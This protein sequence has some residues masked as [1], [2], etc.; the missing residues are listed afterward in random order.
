M[1]PIDVQITI[2]TP[3]ARASA[4]GIQPTGMNARTSIA[5]SATTAP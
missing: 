5:V 4:V 2:C 1:T 3:S